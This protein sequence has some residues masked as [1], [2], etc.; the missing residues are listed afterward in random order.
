[1][2]YPP[3][4][5]PPVPI[6]ATR[7]RRAS[8]AAV[9]LALGFTGALV[10][11]PAANA[12]TFTVTSTNDA[13][14]GSLRQAV[15]DANANP[16]FDTITI[17]LT[18]PATS[19]FI[20]STILVT[21]GVF[22]QGSGA[23]NL[24]ISRSGDF[25]ILDFTMASAD[26]DVVIS[27][28]NFD[29]GSGTTQRGLN[30]RNA[31]PVR[32]L[33]IQSSEFANF[34]TTVRGGAVDISGLSGN[35]IINDTDFHDNISTGNANAPSLFAQGIDSGFV[36]VSSCDFYDNAGESGAGLEIM[37]SDAEVT[38]NDSTF[39]DNQT[40]NAGA[41][42]LL[43][44]LA[45]VTI[46]RTSFDNDDSTGN[47][48]GALYTS[49]IS[50]EVSIEDS[51][52]SDSSSPSNGGAVAATSVGGLSIIDSTFVNNTSGFDGGAVWADTTGES[53]VSG[54]SF[55]LNDA[56][57]GG[58]LAFTDMND[59]VGLVGS[60]FDQNNATGLGG[61][62]YVGLADFVVIL[63]S[64]TFTDNT[65]GGGSAFDIDIVSAP[66]AVNGTT[67]TDNVS[68]DS[69]SF[70]VSIIAPGGAVQF[71]NSTFL[72]DAPTSAGIIEVG[73]INGALNVLSSTLVGNG[74]IFAI[75]NAGSA[76]VSNSIIDGNPNGFADPVFNV[77]GS[78]A[79]ELEYSIVTTALDG[80]NMNST[81]GNL[82]S[83][84]PQLGAL[85]FNGGVT[86]TMLPAAGS[87]A[88]NAGDPAYAFGYITDQRGTGF[89]REN[90][91]VDIGAV[92]AQPPAA[93]AAT[94]TDI[95]PV[96]P[97]GGGVLLLIGALG[98]MLAA[99]RR[100]GA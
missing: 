54:S 90:G 50:G 67:F 65:T 82:F 51:S 87:P 2:Q 89:V 55:S 100:Q 76:L 22:F 5:E 59:G 18:F 56:Q 93:L 32:N 27:G 20:D 15:I 11:A 35:L 92:E 25:E 58:A 17:S 7:A 53:L 83:T 9:T 81:V 28:I 39:N 48:G 68:S 10:A 43:Y 78:T 77:N 91:R 45:G 70:G 41:A 19:I 26:Q 37:F 98:M 12:A 75:A 84:D 88:I 1:M 47:I 97:I 62:L 36:S 99:R 52:F 49:T 29:G 42:A 94:G 63:E 61:A 38:V 71:S 44:G 6:F 74:V 16:G 3:T 31:T 4:K 86:R 13:G 40:T 33:S 64:D 66:V 23:A 46:R 24:L 72:E 79:V 80:A 73:V 8:A 96:V 95:N 57:F 69:A 14:A 85:A 34:V 30:F 21:D 60:T